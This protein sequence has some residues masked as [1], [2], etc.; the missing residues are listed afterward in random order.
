MVQERGR[1]ATVALASKAN[2]PT[3]DRFLDERIVLGSPDSI[4]V[5]SDRPSTPHTAES[6][7]VASGSRPVPS[8]RLHGG[9]IGSGPPDSRDRVYATC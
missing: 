8:F 6:R 9:T 3:F 2:D 7:L 5:F 4:V 1:S